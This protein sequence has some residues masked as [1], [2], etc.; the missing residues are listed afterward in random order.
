LFEYNKLLRPKNNK[1]KKVELKLKEEKLKTEVISEDE[2]L[3]QK[4]W[5]N[6][7]QKPDDD[8]TPYNIGESKVTMNET[9]YENGELEDSMEKSNQTIHSFSRRVKSNLL[10]RD[11][12]D[13]I[14]EKQSLE[15]EDLE[16]CEISEKYSDEILKLYSHPT[17]LAK[18]ITSIEE[19]F[20]SREN[21]YVMRNLTTFQAQNNYKF[22]EDLLPERANISQQTEEDLKEPTSSGRER[23][24][25][26]NFKDLH[27]MKMLRYKV[28]NEEQ[29]PSPEKTLCDYLD[30]SQ[31]N[32]KE[33]MN[34]ESW[35]KIQE[36]VSQ[37]L[38]YQRGRSADINGAKKSNSFLN[39]KWLN[40]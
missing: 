2:Q 5:E 25:K 27:M 8:F 21:G 30:E 40:F 16:D 4:C 19:K 9:K 13:I 15:V 1:T 35:R 23:V 34:I 33:K 26:N 38:K 24:C 29:K 17:S 39:N 6:L 11:L 3:A 28:K 7:L 20:R 32:Q 22:I 18:T 12:I 10:S 37:N 31:M 36:V 14:N